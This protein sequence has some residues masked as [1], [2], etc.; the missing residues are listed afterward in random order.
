MSLVVDE[1]R[2]Y[3]EDR[4]RVSAFR[5]A[6]NETVKPGDV[7][8]DLGSGTGIL[9]LLACQAGA[10]HVYSI[11]GGGMAQLARDIA[12][13]NRFE[14]RITVIKGMSTRTVLPELVD[15]VVADQIGRFG[16]EAGVLEFFAD[17]KR[18]FLK[19]SGI[20]IP[21]RIDLWVAPVEHSAQWKRVDFWSHRPA[22]FGFEPARK[23][24]ENTGYPVQLQA[25]QLLGDPVNAVSLDAL[26]HG[27]TPIAFSK[28]IQIS[29]AGTLHGIGGWFSAQLSAN[30]EMTNSPLAKRRIKRRNV[31]FPIARPVAVA[32]GDSVQLSFSIL[33][34]DTIV[35]WKVEVYSSKGAEQGTNPVARFTHSTLKGMLISREDLVHTNPDSIPVMSI[36]GKAR[37]TVLELCDGKRTLRQIEDGVLLEHPDL[38]PTRTEAAVFAAEVITRYGE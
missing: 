11:D 30:V 20:S 33:P 5:Q 24:A 28:T 16:F 22:G 38:F 26:A 35:T 34:Q 8:L 27:A 10:K 31:F 6:I 3:L 14:D 12:L 29:R 23:I 21:A 7:V 32:S 19:P 37:Q 4:V 25:K 18:R 15:V 2:Q 9:G 13:A 17:A 1:H 36:W